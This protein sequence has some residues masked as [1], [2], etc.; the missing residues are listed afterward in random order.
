MLSCANGYGIELEVQAAGVEASMVELLKPWNLSLLDKRVVESETRAT[1]TLQLGCESK[2]RRVAKN[3]LARLEANTND[4]DTRA[5]RA[6]S[7][8]CAATVKLLCQS[9][10]TV[11]H[12]LCG[13]LEDGQV[14]VVREEVERVDRNAVT[15][16]T[17]TGTESLVAV[18]LCCSGI[19]HLIGI[20][21]VSACCIGHLIDVGNVDH[22][23]AVLEQLG[24]LCNL[25]LADRHYLLKDTSVQLVDD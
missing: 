6:G 9:S 18:G 14:G 13:T 5:S 24:H 1:Q 22:A 21:A 3:T 11:A 2:T 4:K 25:G 10:R 20:D 16:D 23:V 8:G 19:D 7:T 15:S 17:K 12:E